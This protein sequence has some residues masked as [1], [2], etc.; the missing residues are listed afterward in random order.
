MAASASEPRSIP[1]SPTVFFS[2]YEEVDEE[3]FES[4]SGSSP[5]T[6][7]DF[8]IIAASPDSFFDSTSMNV[9]VFDNGKVYRTRN[10]EGNI[11]GRYKSIRDFLREIAI[12]G[13]FSS[14]DLTA[15]VTQ[16]TSMGLSIKREGWIVK[17]VRV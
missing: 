8:P 17:A 13:H 4:G 3:E 15:L 11:M 2:V 5:E 1:R 12:A 16:E 14:D 9:T 10:I 6:D 7:P